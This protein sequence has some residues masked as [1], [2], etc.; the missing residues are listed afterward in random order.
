MNQKDADAKLTNFKKRIN[1]NKAKHL[2]TENELKQ[3]KA[4]D[5][6]Y[7]SDK[8]LFGNDGFRKM[9]VYQPTLNKLQIKYEKTSENVV[10]WKSKGA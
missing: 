7:F 9:F 4:L 5:W 8:N 2:I 6:C 10:S 3:L 1:S